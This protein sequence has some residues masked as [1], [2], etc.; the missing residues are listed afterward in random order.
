MGP[1]SY[2]VILPFNATGESKR[3]DCLNNNPTAH[4]LS[5]GT[6]I[7]VYRG[8]PCEGKGAE[9]LGVAVAPHWNATYVRRENPIVSP[10]MG[11]GAM[12]RPSCKLTWDCPWMP[13]SLGENKPTFCVISRAHG[14]TSFIL[15]PPFTPSMRRFREPRGSVSLPRWPRS[16]AYHHPQPG[17]GHVVWKGE[18]AL[19]WRPS[20]L[21]RHLQVRTRAGWWGRSCVCA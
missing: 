9:S 8:N 7:L 11:T 10:S 1:W 19:V 12:S 3:W 18:P 6:V 16:L 20:V 15:C 14:A 13:P 17:R 4:V 21:N 2:R 5:N